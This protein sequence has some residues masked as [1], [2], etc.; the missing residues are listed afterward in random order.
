[1]QETSLVDQVVQEQ[2]EE[3]IKKSH[4]AYGIL[5]QSLK[6]E[7]LRLV[8]GVDRGNAHGIWKILIGTYDRK[9]MATR[10]QLLEQLFGTQ[11]KVIDHETIASYVARL[12]EL[13]RRL[14]AQGEQISE[15]IM[16][17]MLLRG[18]PAPYTSIVQL[19]KMKEK[20]EFTE[21]VETLKNEE[22]RQGI[23]NHNERQTNHHADAAT[24]RHLPKGCFAC[25]AHDHI[26][27]NCPLHSN[28]KHCEKCHRI[29]HTTQ[30]CKMTVSHASPAMTDS[31]WQRL[32]HH[33]Y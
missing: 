17:Y 18:L 31:T 24:E 10:V 6:D 3:L 5:I 11:L 26:K 13:E 23:S 4:L 27:S 32:L 8:R 25:G 19:M 14:R 29:G 15:G 22:E 7:Q 1:M 16:V 30:E 28:K 2:R 12:T 21:A 20:L 33:G 9:S